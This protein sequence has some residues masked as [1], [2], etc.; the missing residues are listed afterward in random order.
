MNIAELASATEKRDAAYEIKFLV[1]TATAE[2]AL[3]W[4][5]QQLAPD[6]HADGSTGDRYRVNSLYFETP[7]LD[8]YQRHGSYGKSKYR[9][10]R[11]GD[12]RSLFLERKLKSRGLVSKRRTRVTDSE[13]PRLANGLPDPAW[14]GYWFGRRLLARQLLP[15]CQIRYHRTARV[16]MTPQGPIRLTIDRELFALRTSEYGVMER[17]GWVSLLPDRCI[18]ELKFRCVMPDL[19]KGILEQFSL[20]PQPVSKYRLSIQAFGL[21]PA[22]ANAHPGPSNG[23]ASQNPPLA[24]S[25]DIP[26]QVVGSPP[27]A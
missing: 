24:E 13:L 18:L 2:E 20:K 26:Q 14:V 10:R 3:A 21:D 22:P 17:G 27:E 4:A 15:I 7:N 6:S 1:P 9:V 16:S 11:Y 8:V 23:Q 12:E 5:R 25:L 19:F